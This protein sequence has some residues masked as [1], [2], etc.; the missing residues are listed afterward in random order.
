M[1]L[2]TLAL[3]FSVFFA[4]ACNT[5]FWNAAMAG[6]D[7]GSAGTWAFAATLFVFLTAAHLLLLCLVLN[8]WIARPLLVVLI[9]ATA[10]ATYYMRRFTVFLDPT[11]LR[12]V[13]RTDVGEARELFTFGMVPHM[14]LFAVLPV[15]FLLR[16]RI[17]Q[18]GWSRAALWRGGTLVAA[19]VLAVGS[20]LLTFQDF[21]SLMRNNREM[22]YL[23]TPA[24]YLYSLANVAFSHARDARQPRAVVGGDAKLAS[25][26]QQRTKPA[27]MVIVVGETVRAANWG[28]SGYARQ[29]TPQLA[30]RD[31]INFAEVTSCGT[32]TEVSL[33]C[34]F[35]AVGRRNYDEDRIRNSDSLLHI[36]SR[37]GFNV[38]W[39]D[40]QA[41]CKGVCE[42]LAEQRLDKAVSPAFCTGG[43]CFDEILLEGLDAVVQD[44]AG[45]RLIVM[46]QLGNHGP[47]YY[48]RY[49]DAFKKFMPACE[50][51]ELRKCSQQEIVNAFDNAL[52]YTDHVLARTIDWLGRQSARYDTA[53]IYVSD[54]GESLG[55]GGLYL[56]GMPYAIAPKAQ[57]RVPMTMWFSPS[58]AA[59][60]RLDTACLR[61]AAAQ[62]VSH[63]H[64]FHS[65]LGLLQVQTSAYEA[66]WDV[67]AKCRN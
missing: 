9:V 14:L 23:I 45:N 13:V 40:N 1:Q 62:P 64:L 7:A 56:H 24:N 63:D 28:L 22:R 41:G 60:S 33:P 53:M 18:R 21:S 5:L 38:L 31:V 12:N 59:S 11:M 17:A 35:S 4:L 55:E 42:G 19:L 43:R 48:R 47:A 52:L 51:A 15:L 37:A 57:T 2:E 6:R 10:F 20:V 27:L 61:K 54:H 44:G 34:M 67:S 58:F 26:W 16:V 36:L 66:A 29:T 8:R 39:R 32:N 65:V 30:Q 50:T 46:H 3:I 49:P 25:A